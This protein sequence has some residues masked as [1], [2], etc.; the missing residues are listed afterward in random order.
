MCP[1]I[2]RGYFSATLGS[3]PTTVGVCASGQS[4]QSTAMW[5]NND[6]R[7]FAYLT[8]KFTFS[9]RR[10][11]SAKTPHLTFLDRDLGFLAAMRAQLRG[12]SSLSNCFRAQIFPP[13]S[14]PIWRRGL[15]IS[16]QS[17][18]AL[19]I[20][21]A[22]PI[23]N[24]SGAAP[25]VY[26]VLPDLPV[27]IRYQTLGS[28]SSAHRSHSSPYPSPRPRIYSPEGAPWLA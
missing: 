4:L 20:N 8:E 28:R 16:T 25:G 13:C 17:A 23:P 6:C 19:D 7:L 27:L 15:Q 18:D 12:P 11:F 21:H 26:R 24:S 3:A 1:R 9:T 2:R 10:L 5:S 22:D 14:S